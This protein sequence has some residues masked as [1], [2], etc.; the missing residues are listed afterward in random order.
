VVLLVVA[1]VLGYE[2]EELEVILEFGLCE[3]NLFLEACLGVCVEHAFEGLALVEEALCRTFVLHDVY[4]AGSD[5]VPEQFGVFI[6]NGIWWHGI[7]VLFD[8]FPE[9]SVM[10]I[11]FQAGCYLTTIVLS[12]SHGR[13]LMFVS[14]DSLRL[15]MSRALSSMAII[16]GML[17]V[18]IRE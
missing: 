5:E 9:Y 11:V 1:L 7:D 12:S 6:A 16:A 14:R 4:G 10:A 18:W 17:S 3:G 2:V 8:C 13:V 15:F